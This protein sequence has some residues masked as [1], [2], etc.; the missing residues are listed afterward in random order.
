MRHMTRTSVLVFFAAVLALGSAAAAGSTMAGASVADSAST[1]AVAQ[2]VAPM[3]HCTPYVRSA[4]TGTA[5]G[6]TYGDGYAQCSVAAQHT[7]TV[8]VRLHRPFLPDIDVATSTHSGVATYYEA[9]VSTYQ[10][11]EV[12]IEVRT[13]DM[14]ARSPRGQNC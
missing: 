2:D 9:D 10:C 14:T 6:W 4:I 11:G 3:T 13:H 5:D 1:A 7:L 8:V 12:W